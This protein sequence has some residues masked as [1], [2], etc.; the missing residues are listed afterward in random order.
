M[1]IVDASPRELCAAELG[2][3]HQSDQSAYVANNSKDDTNA[4]H[5]KLSSEQSAQ[6]AQCLKITS[7]PRN[8]FDVVIFCLLLEYIPTPAMRL[9]CCLNAYELL[10]PGG[11][12]IIVTPDSKHIGS[13]V[14][15]YKCWQI[16]LASLGFGRIKYD[17]QDH[18]HG[19]VFR[20]GIYKKL[21]QDQSEK[22]L[23]DIKCKRQKEISTS[24][25]NK[26]VRKIN[27]KDKFLHINLDEICLGLLIPQDLQDHHDSDQI[28]SKK[29]EDGINFSLSC[30]QKR[31]LDISESKE[32]GYIPEVKREKISIE[33]E[34]ASEIEPALR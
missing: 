30:T 23:N 24:T 12:L 3:P 28:T 11:L 18:F 19:M 9:K 20:K 14:F 4:E 10:A 2:N 34:P 5:T 16:A 25:K 32:I 13:N 7:L 8:S 21:W 6:Q 22:I 31:V 17:K 26:Q 27:K 29:C 33:I 1:D 15:L